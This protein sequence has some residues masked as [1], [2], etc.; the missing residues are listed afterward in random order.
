MLDLF[1]HFQLD[2]TGRYISGRPLSVL[3]GVP[4]VPAYSNLDVRLAW[5]FKQLELSLVGQNIVNPSHVEFATNRIPR[6]IY[7]KIALRF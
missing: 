1:R 7:A 6:N 4:V 5:Y 3:A 2:I